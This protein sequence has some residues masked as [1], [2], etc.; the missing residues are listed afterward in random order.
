MTPGTAA[1]KAPLG[2]TGRVL[3]E[4]EV[5]S[6]STVCQV[7][8]ALGVSVQLAEA[9]LRVL[10]LEGRAVVAP[11]SDGVRRWRALEASR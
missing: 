10:A 8:A 4:L 2:L 6:P 5:T 9:A 1:A 3:A 11:G 7:A